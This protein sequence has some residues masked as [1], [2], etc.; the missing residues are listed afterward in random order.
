MPLTH[1]DSQIFILSSNFSKFH[2]PSSRVI[3]RVSDGLKTGRPAELAAKAVTGDDDD[4][5][6]NTLLG[7]IISNTSL[8]A[9][10]GSEQ[11]QFIWER[12]PIWLQR[13]H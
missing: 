9:P 7:I 8:R 6:R 4:A 1:V 2:F 3:N 5:K 11:L 12:I 13:E 10:L